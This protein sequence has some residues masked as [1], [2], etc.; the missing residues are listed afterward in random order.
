MARRR[1][2]WRVAKWVGTGACVAV[3]LMA[4]T[5]LV[6]YET[7]IRVAQ[8]DLSIRAGAVY[9]TWD[10]FRSPSVWAH[11]YTET[12]PRGMAW[13]EYATKLRTRDAWG[14]RVV[15]LPL[16]LVLVGFGA[17]TILSWWLDRRVAVPGCCRCCGYDLTGNVSGVCPECGTPIP[18]PSESKPKE[19][20]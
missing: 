9:I 17:P 14:E 13:R 15:D 3:V 5:S 7:G 11:P 18:A 16:W 8:C 2:V 4:T 1:K 19:T 10:D 6:S 12:R 20:S